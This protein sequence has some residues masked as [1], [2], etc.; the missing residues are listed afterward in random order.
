MI[1]KCF[2]TLGLLTAVL[3]A[4][5]QTYIAHKIEFSQLGSFTQKQLEDA[6]GLQM[7]RPFSAADLSAAAQRLIDTGYFDGVDATLDGKVTAVTVKFAVK[8]IELAHMLHIGFENFVWLTQNEIE[9]VIK[10]KFPLFVDYL[11]ENSPHLDEIK[12]VL[13]Q[14]LAAKSITAEVGYDTFEPT[15]RHPM[16]EVGF[17]VLSPKIHVANI[18][19]GGVTPPLVP[20]IQK[21]VN[22]TALT[23]YTQGPADETTEDRILAPLLD[24][25]YIQA[26]LT[27]PML[28]ASPAAHDE[29]GITLSATLHSG[30]VFHLSQLTFAGT[31]LFSAATFAM[32]AK[33]HPGDLASSAA[34][35]ATLKPIDAAYR[36][37][38]YMDVVVAAIP[39]LDSTARTVAYTVNVQ[40]GEQYRIHEVSTNNIPSAA[41]ADF[42]RAF[43]MKAGELYNPEYAAGFLKSNKALHVF[44]GY[45]ANFKAYADP[46]THTVDLV[47]TFVKMEPESEA[48]PTRSS[49][50]VSK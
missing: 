45:F 6:T 49:R 4:N 33:L 3:H 42:N 50:V 20:L 22:A 30:E 38:G 32:S 48:T 8:P 15:L 14:T 2:L 23:Q 46:E 29:I 36:R 24:A 10:T 7:G 19:L 18:K 5:A 17:R 40:P 12:A 27:R 47:V 43:L 9:A 11:P 37:K 44:D 21:S 28:T 39:T 16:R 31:D 25:G 35:L 41:G 1:L 13:I 34:L 26:S